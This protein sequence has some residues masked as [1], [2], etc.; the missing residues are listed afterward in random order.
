MKV[1]EFQL[2]VI[3]NVETLHALNWVNEQSEA[4]TAG[5]KKISVS[6]PTADRIPMTESTIKDGLSVSRALSAD[7]FEEHPPVGK[8]TRTDT[9]SV[10]QV[11]R[12][13]KAY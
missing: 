6:F 2:A 7:L 12:M 3:S 8:R 11:V 10:P 1:Q 5:K 4:L 13:K 9:K